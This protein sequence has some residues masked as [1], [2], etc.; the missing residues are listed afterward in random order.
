M[1]N[2]KSSILGHV[3]IAPH[4]WL[5]VNKANTCNQYFRQLCTSLGNSPEEI[6]ARVLE[7]VKKFDRID[8]AK[9]TETADF[10]KDLSLD[11]LDRSELIMA[12]EE[13]FSIEIPD[14]HADK[15]T[16]CA[17]VAKYITTASQKSA[18]QS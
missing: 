4:R 10:G 3:R 11:S 6:K 16:C 17:D 14:N 12:F 8:A 13:E 5:F 7:L 2:I 9:V 1:Q 18:E 15:F